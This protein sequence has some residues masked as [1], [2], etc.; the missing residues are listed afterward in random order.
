MMPE[1]K[2]DIRKVLKILP[3]GGTPNMF[4]HPE[5]IHYLWK[6]GVTPLPLRL[7]TF[8]TPPIQNLLEINRNCKVHKGTLRNINEKT[9]ELRL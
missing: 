4:T 8:P 9:E 2:N 1:N 3:G 7:P 5:G 6:K